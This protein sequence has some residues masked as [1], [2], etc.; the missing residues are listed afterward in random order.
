M[1][2]CELPKVNKLLKE[3]CRVVEPGSLLFLLHEYITNSNIPGLKKIGFI[4]VTAVPNRGPRVLN[5]YV[6]LPEGESEN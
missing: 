5:I 4:H 1:Y 2:N 3:G 6:K